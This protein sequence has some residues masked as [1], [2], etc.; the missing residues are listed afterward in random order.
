VIEKKSGVRMVLNP[1]YP[2]DGQITYSM[3]DAITL[4]PETGPEES[5]AFT[6]RSIR[7]DAS[8]NA[9]VLDIEDIRIKIYDVNGNWIRNVGQ[10]GQGPGEYMNINDFDVTKE[11]TITILDIPQ[12][13]ITVL[14]NMGRFVSSFIFKGNWGKLRTDE[15]GHV[16]IHQNISYRQDGNS[17]S[18]MMEM[19][20]SRTDLSGKDYFEYGI[21]PYYLNVWRPVKSAGGI[22]VQNHFS[23]EAHS[24]VWIPD[25]EGH[26][27]LGYSKDYLISVLDKKGKPIFKFGRKFQKIRHPEYSPDLAH[28]KHYP[29]F[30]SSYLFFDDEGNLWLKQYMKNGEPEHVYDVFSPEGIYIQQAVVPTRIFQL[31]NGIAYTI[32][33]YERGVYEAKR[34]RLSAISH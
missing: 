30:N 28:P 22:R 12:R 5:I 26:I 19:T 14:T 18:K 24:T 1:D 34:F 17:G 31:R 21:F 13:R 25:D 23:S 16:Y 32:I 15:T 3:T 6:P 20:L 9:Y 8:G 27:Y 10:R 2:R 4:G 29:A 7:V 33:R 11:G